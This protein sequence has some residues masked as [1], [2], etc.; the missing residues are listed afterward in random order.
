MEDEKLAEKAYETLKRIQAG[1]TK[2]FPWKKRKKSTIAL[3]D[4]KLIYIHNGNSNDRQN[5]SSKVLW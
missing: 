2:T 4:V 5:S 1:K 3:F